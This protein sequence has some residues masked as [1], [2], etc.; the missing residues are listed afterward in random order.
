MLSVS[1]LGDFRITDNDTPVTGVDTPRL[2]SLLAYLL[3]HSGV[4]QSRAHVAFL[5]WP[6]STEGQAR[7]NLRHVL[8]HLRRAL[9]D[10]NAFL[11]ADAKTLWWRPDAPYILDVNQFYAALDEAEQASLGSGPSA[12]RELLEQAL[13]LYKGELLPSCY[14]DW[15]LPEREQLREAHF[16][17]TEQLVQMLEDRRQGS[18][19][20]D[21]PRAGCGV[22]AALCTGPWPERRRPWCLADGEAGPR[23]RA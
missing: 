7:T 17:A 13:S 20:R 22:R 15:I 10:A 5:F 19:R 9:P 8:Y 6:D 2:Q 1:L 3:L 12:A 14:D 4:P 18:D 11:H 23:S 16:G 21:D